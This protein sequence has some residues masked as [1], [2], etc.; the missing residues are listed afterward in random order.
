MNC[1]CRRQG[2]RDLQRFLLADDLFQ[3]GKKSFCCLSRRPQLVIPLAKMPFGERLPNW[4]LQLNVFFFFS[5]FF[6]ISLS[7]QEPL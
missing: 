2:V 1:L 6:K 3:E 5:F 4:P 7:Q